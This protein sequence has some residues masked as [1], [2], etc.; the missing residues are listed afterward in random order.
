M[1][2]IVRHRLRSQASLV[3]KWEEIGGKEKM[4]FLEGGAISVTSGSMSAS[5]KYSF[6]DDAHVKVEFEGFMALAGPQIQSFAISDGVLTLTDAKG[7]VSKYKKT[8]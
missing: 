1:S 5:G 3:G 8:P 2:G 7:K 4:E 6:P